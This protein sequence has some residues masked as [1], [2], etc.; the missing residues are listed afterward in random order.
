[1]SVNVT[2]LGRTLKGR[3]DG[4]QFSNIYRPGLPVTG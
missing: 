3:K 1:M 2:R 4:Q